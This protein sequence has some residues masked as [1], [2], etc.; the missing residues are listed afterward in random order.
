[1]TEN[2]Q[3][4]ELIVA[5]LR[6]RGLLA[7]GALPLLEKMS[8]D[9]SDRGFYRIEIAGG[10]SLIGV[11]PSP[12]L[13]RGAEEQAAAYRIGVHLHD[14]GVPVPEIAGYDPQNGLLLF[15]DLGNIQLHAVVRQASSFAEVEPLYHQAIDGLIRL[16][17]EGARDFDVRLCWDTPCYDLSLMLSR[18][19]DYFRFSFCRDYMGKIADAPGLLLE[20]QNIARRAAREPARY[21]LHRDFQSRNLLVHGG[22]VHII[23]YQG[24]RLGPLGY[25]LASLL[26]DPYA[27]LS[28]ESQE[29]LYGYYYDTISTELALDP[30]N[31]RAGYYC[32]ALQRNLQ[33]LG[34]FAFL[35]RK[36]GKVFFEQFILPAL[37]SLMALLHDPLGREYTSLAGLVGELEEQLNKAQFFKMDD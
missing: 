27:G 30:E 7:G 15:A 1:M 19:S 5:L 18:E 3:E 33:I 10:R 13:A 31:F 8:G 34:A 23:D 24:A 11:F 37:A 35:S 32:L 17:L 28:R 22:K 14:K 21:L 2:N 16:Q 25:D 4:K 20:L 12:T 9:G 26:L 36:K 6:A 29:A